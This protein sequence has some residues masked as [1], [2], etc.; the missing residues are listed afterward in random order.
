MRAPTSSTCLDLPAMVALINSIL[1]FGKDPLDFES[2]AGLFIM[3]TREF[4]LCLLHSIMRGNNGEE[5]EQS[6]PS[7]YQLH[8][9]HFEAARQFTVS[10]VAKQ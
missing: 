6:S 10:I 7:L 4:E 9:T 8:A 1:D 5:S 2:G 3:W